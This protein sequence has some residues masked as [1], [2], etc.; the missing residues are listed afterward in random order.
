MI[1]DLSVLAVIPARGGSKGIKLKNLR[2][3]AGLPLVVIAGKIAQAIS[4]I[5]RCVVST[6]NEKI[7]E[8]AKLASIEVPFMRPQDIAGDEVG[9]WDVLNHALKTMEKID[10]IKYDI[11]V[12][13]QP[14]SPLR[15]PDMVSDVI[16]KLVLNNY[17][18]VW[19]VSLTDSKYHPLKQLIISD[20]GDLDYFDK[21]GEA[22]IA[23]QQLK[24]VYHRNGVAYAFTRECILNQKK[25]MGKRSGVHVITGKQISIDTEEDIEEVEKCMENFLWAQ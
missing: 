9:D 13:L 10:K 22:I 3:V 17:D 12:M 18:S 5:D 8:V 20:E 14:T 7:A 2:V 4:L 21:A 6:D 25:I 19:S 16:K 11:V 24:N 15:T 23:R 1:N